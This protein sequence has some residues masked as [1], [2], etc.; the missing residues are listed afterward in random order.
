MC[1][2][3]QGSNEVTLR[4]SNAP[5]LLL[6]LLL[7]LLLHHHLLVLPSMIE[8]PFRPFLT[9]SMCS[10]SI[11]TT[12]ALGLK[13]M[14]PYTCYVMPLVSLTPMLSVHALFLINLTLPFRTL[15]TLQNMVPDGI[16]FHLQRPLS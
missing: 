1:L 4:L 12:L 14:K 7:L 5:H 3:H 2:R 11:L 9:N 6:L 15:S 8:N 13:T 16:H 10:G